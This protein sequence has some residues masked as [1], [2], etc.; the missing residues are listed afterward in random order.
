MSDG[1]SGRS[2]ATGRMPWRTLIVVA[3]ALLAIS[4]GLVW[5]FS[6]KP[7]TSTEDAYVRA[8]KTIVSPKVRGA[9]DA[10][11][12]RE[13]QPVK[14]GDPL[15]RLDPEE[16]DLKVSAAQGD[17]MAADAAAQAARA[18]LARLAAEEKLSESQVK[19]AEALAG[20]KG[21][22]DP[23]LRQAFETA[24]GQAL[25]AV[26][27]RGEIEA[28]LAQ[29]R[30]AQFRAHTELDAAKAEKGHTLVIAPA[31]GIVADVEATPGA[32]VQPGVRLMTIVSAGAP[33]LTAN[34]KE[35]QTGRMRAGQPA[36]VK[37]DA[38]PGLT[39][40][41][42]VDSLAPGSGSEFALLPFEPGAGNFTKIV[43]R[44][45]VRISLDPGQPG[46]DRL[47]PGLSAEVTV[48]LKPAGGAD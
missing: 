11:L 37:I 10:V 25:I 8:D 41:G 1:G 14:A 27:S 9:I 43:Q 35:T 42:K 30:A 33:Y 39:F 7:D 13:N 21:A 31:G 3:L 17:L 32:I 40:T 28:D 48:R 47:R 18:G 24:R 44:V 19:G 4:A 29:A 34:F 6:D 20:A 15:V 36:Q 46:L 5:I 2:A 23:A 12:V 45:P 38:L 22:A 26:R 16:Y